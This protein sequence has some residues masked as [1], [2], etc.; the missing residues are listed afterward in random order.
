MEMLKTASFVEYGLWLIMLGPQ[1]FRLPSPF[2]RCLIFSTVLSKC[3]ELFSVKT[4]LLLMIANLFV[5]L[6]YDNA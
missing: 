6:L 5:I 4:K 3:E 2:P 1:D